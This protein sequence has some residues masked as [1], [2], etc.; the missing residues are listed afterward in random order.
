MY[1]AVTQPYMAVFWVRVKDSKADVQSCNSAV[2]GCIL[3]SVY[4]TVTQPYMAVFWNL[5]TGQ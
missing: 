2:H 3:E 5:C 4:R 1:K